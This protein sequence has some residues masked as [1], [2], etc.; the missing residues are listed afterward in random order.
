[1]S[2]EE[3]YHI[4]IITHS[5]PGVK[6]IQLDLSKEQLN[7]RF[8]RFYENGNNIFIN[9]KQ[10]GTNDI[11]I[12]KINRT[13]ENSSILIS[14]K[15]AKEKSLGFCSFVSDEWHASSEGEDITNDL[16]L[17]PPGYKKSDSTNEYCKEKKNVSK[18]KKV[19]IVHGHDKEMKQAVARVLEKLDLEPIILHEEPNKGRTVIEKV[20]DCSEDT[21]FAIVLLSPDDRGCKVNNFPKSAKLRARQNVILEMGYFIGKLGRNNVLGIVKEENDFERPS[22]IFG[23]LFTPFKTGWELEMVKELQSCGYNVDANKLLKGVNSKAK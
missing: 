6:Q 13:K 3:Y 7:E 22:D 14:R 15:K 23:I 17:G 10:I 18:N 16:I 8:L 20:E 2:E 9:G 5:N 12:I 1:M 4:L 19:F 11:D 21:Q